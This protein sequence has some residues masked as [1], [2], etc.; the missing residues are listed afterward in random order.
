MISEAPIGQS[1]KSVCRVPIPIGGRSSRPVW[2]AMPERAVTPLPMPRQP[3]LG[4]P[5]PMT[6]N[7]A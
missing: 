3:R 6:G 4:P 7:E 5:L 2:P 1:V